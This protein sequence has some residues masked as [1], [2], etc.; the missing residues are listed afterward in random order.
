MRALALFLSHTPHLRAHRHTYTH[1]AW[2][3]VRGPDHLES[4]SR[5]RNRLATIYACNK[6]VNLLA[7]SE[8]TTLRGHAQ[9]PSSCTIGLNRPATLEPCRALLIPTRS[10]PGLGHHPFIPS[11]TG[12]CSA[13]R[14]HQLVRAFFPHLCTRQRRHRAPRCAYAHPVVHTS[15]ARTRSPARLNRRASALPRRTISRRSNSRTRLPKP[16]AARSRSVRW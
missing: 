15:R 16:V 7:Q 5:L 8:P 6:T 11:R 9:T 13:C 14:P 3:S 1:N 12:A 2:L 4:T 10:S